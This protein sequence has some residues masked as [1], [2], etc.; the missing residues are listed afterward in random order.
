MTT[1]FRPFT[2]DFPIILV[3]LALEIIEKRNSWPQLTLFNIGYSGWI[4]SVIFTLAGP[5][6]S[7][8]LNPPLHGHYNTIPKV[9]DH[10][11]T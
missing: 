4:N 11:V 2:R 8:P 9:F 10:V 1:I 5:G 7:H 6:V 3:T